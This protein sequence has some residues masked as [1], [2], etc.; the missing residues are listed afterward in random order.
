MRCENY[1]P[2]IPNKQYPNYKFDWTRF[3]KDQENIHF[4][5]AL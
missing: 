5:T 1:F 2:Y 4:S 3:Y